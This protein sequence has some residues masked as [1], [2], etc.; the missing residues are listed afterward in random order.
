MDLIELVIQFLKVLG[1]L[2]VHEVNLCLLASLLRLQS[3][4]SWD[5]L[6]FN[7]W[8]KKTIHTDTYILIS[9]HTHKYIY[10]THIFISHILR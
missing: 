3:R 6:R 1:V 4:I 9:I 10:S 5:I 2:G 8:L 7:H